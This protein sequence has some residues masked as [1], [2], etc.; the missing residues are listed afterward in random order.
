MKKKTQ[1]IRLIFTII[2]VL[3]SVLLISILINIRTV[4]IIQ[5]NV[6]KQA[7]YN[8][9]GSEY[10]LICSD[11]EKYFSEDLLKHYSEYLPLTYDKALNCKFKK[12]IVS[13]NI[14]TYI[15]PQKVRVIYADNK[16]II[17]EENNHYL[18]NDYYLF[19]SH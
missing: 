17:I 8:Y 15:F 19:I 10:Y 7:V 16:P 9:N 18:E 13:G 6:E 3:L 14:Q 12:Y 11:N 5:Y 2:L 1:K 4:E